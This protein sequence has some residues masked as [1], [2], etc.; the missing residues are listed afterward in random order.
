MIQDN[1]FSTFLVFVAALSIFFDLVGFGSD[2]GRVLGRFGMVLG[3]FGE[4]FWVDLRIWGEGFQQRALCV[5]AC[6]VAWVFGDVNKKLQPRKREKRYSVPAASRGHN[7]K[8]LIY[9]FSWLHFP[10]G[11]HFLGHSIW[12]GGMREAIKSAAPCRRAKR[13]AKSCT[14]SCKLP[15]PIQSWCRVR[16]EPCK[17]RRVLTLLTSRRPRAL[18]RRAHN[19]VFFRPFFRPAFRTPKK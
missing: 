13:N 8:M 15:A 5:F 17:T 19:P 1:F 16:T 3:W 12:P 11:C 14:E 7:N 4:G 10:C 9:S 6:L 2:F 18:R